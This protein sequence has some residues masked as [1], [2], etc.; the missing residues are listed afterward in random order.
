MRRLRYP[1]YHERETQRRLAAGL[2]ENIEDPAVLARVATILRAAERSNGGKKGAG[3]AH[4]P[5]SRAEQLDGGH[6][7]NNGAPT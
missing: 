7:G 6:E 3:E 4:P 1:G 2:P 5:A